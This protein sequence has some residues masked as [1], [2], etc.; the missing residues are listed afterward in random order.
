MESTWFKMANKAVLN[1]NKIPKLVN[2]L[3]SEQKFG[4][5][6]T[7]TDLHLTLWELTEQTRSNF[8]GKIP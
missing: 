5:R 6:V 7:E 1:T 3:N 8:G 2:F 4:V